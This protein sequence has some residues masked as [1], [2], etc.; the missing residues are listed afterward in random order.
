MQKQK[1][2]K[3]P[4]WAIGAI[5]FAFLVNILFPVFI[6][7][8]A[9]IDSFDDVEEDLIIN[10]TTSIY[11]EESETYIITGTI[12]NNSYDYDY[13]YITIEYTLYDVNG[14]VIGMSSDYLDH[15]EDGETWRFSAEYYGMDASEISYYKLTELEGY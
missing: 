9:F 5:I 15:L 12:Y 8:I 3:M 10:Q 2:K 1:N 7:I 14:N 4:K 13:D 6:V 11:D